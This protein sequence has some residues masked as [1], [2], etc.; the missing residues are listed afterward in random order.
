MADLKA[1]EA[2][3][4]KELKGKGPEALN[5]RTLEGI[6]VKPLYTAADVEGLPVRCGPGC[7]LAWLRACRRCDPPRVAMIG[8]AAVSGAFDDDS[9]SVDRDRLRRTP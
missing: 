1:W 9:N 4:S 6:T 7:R 2:L 5:W 8:S 3:A